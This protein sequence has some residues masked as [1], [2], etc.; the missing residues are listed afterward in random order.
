MQWFVDAT[1]W[2]YRVLGGIVA[3]YA[4]GIWDHWRMRYS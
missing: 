2:I 1:P 3:V 4:I